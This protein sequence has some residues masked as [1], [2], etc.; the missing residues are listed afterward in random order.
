MATRKRGPIQKTTERQ[1]RQGG[2]RKD[3]VMLGLNSVLPFGMILVRGLPSRLDPDYDYHL[4]A[5]DESAHGLSAALS[6]GW[7]LL[8]SSADPA[9][10]RFAGGTT[11]K[12]GEPLKSR[13]LYATRR[14]KAAGA[15]ERAYGQAFREGLAA[16]L[17]G[18]SRAARE[19]LVE[20]E[21]PVD[22]RYINDEGAEMT[23]RLVT[24]HRAP[25]P[26]PEYAE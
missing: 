25:N 23:E 3:P 11:S 22:P 14:T 1:A 8:Q 12:P 9:E 21:M 24:S 17:K 2:S 7:E 16:R 19:A 26:Y 18:R 15:Q 10:P 20:R 5:D 6:T 13:G 4:W